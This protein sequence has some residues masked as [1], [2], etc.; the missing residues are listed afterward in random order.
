MTHDF[1]QTSKV[2]LETIHR[3]NPQV[4]ADACF[5]KRLGKSYKTP[6]IG[7]SPEKLWKG[8]EDWKYSINRYC[9]RGQDW[10][11]KDSIGIFGCSFVFGTG[12]K[13]D[14][15]TVLAKM[16]NENVINMGIP[17]AGP[18]HIIKN[19][20]SFANLHPMS[21]AIISLPPKERF[22][23]PDAS[24]DGTWT[25]YSLTPSQDDYIK[26]VTLPEHLQLST[27][28]DAI[29]WANT[30]AEAKKIKLIWTSWD[31]TFGLEDMTDRYFDWGDLSLDVARDGMH[32]GPTVIKNFAH[33]CADMLNT[34]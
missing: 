10:S 19:F 27:I 33:R 25:W 23:Y 18:L 2:T 12:V 21:H 1:I 8:E 29:D 34:L 6:Y 30:I 24:K 16:L 26:K 28:L 4:Y 14:S 31:Y 17:G 20:A 15:A 9:F 22:F 3:Q 32:P 11:F 5:K 7:R 13:K